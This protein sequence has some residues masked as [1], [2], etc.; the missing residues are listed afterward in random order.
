M[1]ER[2]R[3][4]NNILHDWKRVFIGN[5]YYRTCRSYYSA[6][7]KKTIRKRNRFFIKD[8]KGNSKKGKSRNYEEMYAF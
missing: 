5:N 6:T 3:A 7:Y 8:K 1:I 2:Q 4:R